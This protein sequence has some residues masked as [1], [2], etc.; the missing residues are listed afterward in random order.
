MI[1]KDWLLSLRSVPGQDLLKEMGGMFFHHNLFCLMRQ[2][3]L[4]IIQIWQSDSHLH[5]TA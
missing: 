2:R 3:C 1:L 5:Y 4:V